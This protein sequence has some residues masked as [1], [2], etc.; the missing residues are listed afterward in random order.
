MS[1]MDQ[2]PEITGEDMKGNTREQRVEQAAVEAPANITPLDT[3]DLAKL[4]AAPEAPDP[5]L[6]DR[7]QKIEL[8]RAT[9]NA[10]MEA[11]PQTPTDGE[12][13]VAPGS[14]EEAAIYANMQ[15]TRRGGIDGL[16]PPV[17]A[18]APVDTTPAPTIET[19]AATEAP[20][21][22]SNQAP[23]VTPDATETPKKKHWWSRKVQ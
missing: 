20:I 22:A 2:A 10:A 5:I 18:P 17:S 23:V 9:A 6:D 12:P 11:M 4:D 3:V 1:V 15:A 14:K 8:A 19:A 13:V 21:A 7:Q 16:T